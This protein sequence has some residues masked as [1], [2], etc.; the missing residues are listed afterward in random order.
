[1]SGNIDETVDPIIDPAKARLAVLRQQ[2]REVCTKLQVE[3]ARIMTAEAY[4]DLL[5]MA[6]GNDSNIPEFELRGEEGFYLTGDMDTH[7]RDDIKMNRVLGIE[8]RLILEGTENCELNGLEYVGGNIAV[9]E[10]KNISL[11]RLTFACGA[12]D[13]ADSSDISAPSV[14]FVEGYANI[15]PTRMVFGTE[16]TTIAGPVH[17]FSRRGADAYKV[18]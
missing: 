1:M 17:D 13:M 6:G 12:M 11:G 3:R 15:C 9:R 14:L 2:S 8:G 10:C 4:L 16:N 5:D 18:S 7:G